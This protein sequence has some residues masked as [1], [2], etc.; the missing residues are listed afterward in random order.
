MSTVFS[1]VKDFLKDVEVMSSTDLEADFGAQSRPWATRKQPVYNRTD[2]DLLKTSIASY[3]LYK[4]DTS[5]RFQSFEFLH[6]FFIENNSYTEEDER[7]VEVISN[8]FLNQIMLT[9]LK[10]G[11]ISKWQ[12]GVREWLSTDRT[13]YAN[14]QQGLIYRLP[15]YYNDDLELEAMFTGEFYNYSIKAD[16]NTSLGLGVRCLL[17]IKRMIKNTRGYQSVQYWLKDTATGAPILL[18]LQRDNQL[19]YVWDAIFECGKQ[20]NITAAY[21]KK[22]HPRGND[23]IEGIKWKVN[24][25]G[26]IS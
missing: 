15:E 17:P 19:A 5:H 18:K 14:E 13:I 10:H 22:Q 9:E 4:D 21:Y 11:N 7:L 25:D 3:R 2:F 24:L 12:T 1:N 16:N 20:L 6:R 8:H 23:Y 26:L